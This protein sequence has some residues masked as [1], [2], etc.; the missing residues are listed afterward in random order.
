MQ[1]S[2]V[3]EAKITPGALLDRVENGEEIARHGKAVARLVPNV[4]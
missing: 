3:L 4:S 2:G 1:E